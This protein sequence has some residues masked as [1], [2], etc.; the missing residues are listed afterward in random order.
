MAKYYWGALILIILL[1]SVAIVYKD[2][3]WK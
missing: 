2:A 3:R 1:I